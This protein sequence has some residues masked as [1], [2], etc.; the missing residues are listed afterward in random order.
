MRVTAPLGAIL[1]GSFERRL[2]LVALGSLAVRLAY[3]LVEKRG[4]DT[5]GEELC[6]D[7]FYY[8][9]QADLN[10]A[11]HWFQIRTTEAGPLVEAADHPP[12]TALVSTPASLVFGE[13]VMAQRI[14][15]VAVGVAA[16]IVIG[17]LGR[18]VAGERVGLLAAGL[19]AVHPV[20]WVNDVNV[21]A[22]S[23]A[24]LLVAAT[25]LMLYRFHEEPDW[26]N[27]VVLGA[28]CGLAT[29]TRAELALLVPIT[30][31][32]VALWARSLE[33]GARVGRFLL[34]GVV[35]LAVVAP[36]SIWNLSRF[37]EP[38]LL[39][40]NDGL[41]LLGANCDQV[42]SGGA[43]GFWRLDCA[44]RTA[45]EGDQSEQ[46]AAKRE[47]ALDYMADHASRLPSVMMARVGRTWNLYAP[48]QTVWLNQG[49]GRERWVS[50]AA[51]WTHLV[52]LP[53]AVAGAF[54]LRRRRRLVWPLIAP[55]VLV[56]LTSALF[57]GI[58]RFRVPADVAIV[59]LVA[60]ALDAGWRRWGEPRRRLAAG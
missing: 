26:G 6:G 25:L 34:V 16:V 51:F 29:L 3:T 2:G 38:V 47:A 12:L 28:L 23:L 57:Y 31:L 59:V 55:A 14:T 20:L 21:M 54:L 42:Y 39:S 5:C 19:A 50:W 37:E 52:L 45:N 49:E 58:P 48:D 15:M 35:S 44:L 30:V 1:G 9:A 46:A 43:T 4:A 18:R 36:W 33:V 60:V 41:T 53:L 27:A 24:A 56:T 32:P 40:T 7:A 10:A 11:G 8:S 13:H 17:L 22:E